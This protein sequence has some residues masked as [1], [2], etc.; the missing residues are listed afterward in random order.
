[1]STAVGIRP[2]H[3][4]LP[5]CA[6]ALPSC[7]GHH[8]VRPAVAV[9]AAAVVD[10]GGQHPALHAPLTAA[11]RH[12]VIVAVLR[13]VYL[14]TFSK[15]VAITAPTGIA[16]SNIGGQTV[17][18]ISHCKVHSSSSSTRRDSTPPYLS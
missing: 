17:Q 2:L 8:A 4:L 11:R 14:M 6:V 3:G 12:G 9:V 10:R 16:A 18:P 5:R 1:M 7:T 13:S 15:A